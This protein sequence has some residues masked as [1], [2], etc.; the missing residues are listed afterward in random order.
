MVTNPADWV[1]QFRRASL[2][3]RA[4]PVGPLAQLRSFR[5]EEQPWDEL[6]GVGCGPASSRTKWCHPAASVKPPV[7]RSARL[8]KRSVLLTRYDERNACES[9]GQC[10]SHLGA[11]MCSDLCSA[12]RGGL[13]GLSKEGATQS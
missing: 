3:L 4:S 2:E 10:P 11:L 5:Q 13:V 1:P 12:E 9:K 6:D 7:E 8:Q